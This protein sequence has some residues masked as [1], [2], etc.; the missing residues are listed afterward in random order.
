MFYN[1]MTKVTLYIGKM[2]TEPYMIATHCVIRKRAQR[3]A[4]IN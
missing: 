1:L 3:Q 2:V 4:L